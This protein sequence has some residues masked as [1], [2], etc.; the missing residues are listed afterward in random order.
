MSLLARNCRL[1]TTEPGLTHLAADDLREILGCED[2]IAG[3]KIKF[4]IVQ[5]WVNCDLESRAAHLEHMMSYVRF[6]RMDKYELDL[7]LKQVELLPKALIPTLLSRSFNCGSISFGTAAHMGPGN[8]DGCWPWP[9]DY[10]LTG[11]ETLRN[12]FRF[13]IAHYAMS[14]LIHL[15]DKI[16]QVVLKFE[17]RL[18]E[19]LRGLSL[20]EDISHTEIAVDIR[21]LN[22]NGDM[23]SFSKSTTTPRSS[24]LELLTGQEAL[25]L[26]KNFLKKEPFVCTVAVQLWYRRR[27][28]R[29][30]LH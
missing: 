24:T 22:G 15:E 5:Q 23:L 1:I 13:S 20:I 8:D 4:E 27:N 28:E 21:L 2:L 26:G 29:A 12:P 10:V 11:S 18:R 25:A 17:H 9:K 6:E 30:P 7:V 16:F 14:S 3:E 19:G